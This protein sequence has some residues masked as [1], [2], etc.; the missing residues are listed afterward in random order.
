MCVWVCVRMSLVRAVC[1]LYHCTLARFLDLHNQIYVLYIWALNCS[2]FFPSF[3]CIRRASYH[4]YITPNPT[5]S[6]SNTINTKYRV[7]DERSHNRSPNIRTNEHTTI[8]GKLWLKHSAYTYFS[9]SSLYGEWTHT[10]THTLLVSCEFCMI[11]KYCC[12]MNKLG[13]I[14]KMQSKNSRMKITKF[15]LEFAMWARK[16]KHKEW[17]RMKMCVRER[18]IKKSG[19]CLYLCRIQPFYERK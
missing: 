14:Y 9:V 13:P 10:H 18:E 2:A 1:I 11:L 16:R 6:S 5:D 7:E 15:A 4:A 3:V 12:Y 19:K 8:H 17:M